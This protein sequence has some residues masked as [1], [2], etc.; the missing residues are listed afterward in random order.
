MTELQNLLEQAYE[1]QAQAWESEAHAYETFQA[2][3]KRLGVKKRRVRKPFSK[4]E[5]ARQQASRVRGVKPDAS[6]AKEWASKARERAFNNFVSQAPAKGI[7]DDMRSFLK[8]T[9][10]AWEAAETAW[11][12]AGDAWEAV[13]N[14]YDEAGAGTPAAE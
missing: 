4:I 10:K 6:Q 3:L 7:A 2:E 13:A 9:F 14:K 12:K 1:A 8:D 5:E 11:R